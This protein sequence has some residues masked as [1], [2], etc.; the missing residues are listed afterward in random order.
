MVVGNIRRNVCDICM[1]M[2]SLEQCDSFEIKRALSSSKILWV[3]NER[4]YTN[5]LEEKQTRLKDLLD[6]WEFN[7]EAVTQS[8]KSNQETASYGG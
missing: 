7:R 4:F 1:E 2:Q 3:K 5:R 6:Q 8:E